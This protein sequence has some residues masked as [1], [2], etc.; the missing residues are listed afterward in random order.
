MDNVPPA[1]RIVDLRIGTQ[2]A[3]DGGPPERLR[4]R[5]ALQQEGR[6]TRI[7]A[8]VL[9]PHDLRDS[10][11]LFRHNGDTAEAWYYNPVLDRVRR[12]TGSGNTQAL[13]GTA[14]SPDDF[15][16]VERALRTASITLRP[17]RDDDPPDQRRFIVLPP[18]G[19]DLPLSRILLNVHTEYCVI[20]RAE[21]LDRS[22][23]P[24][25]RLIVPPGALQR[26]GGDRYW[27]P[28]RM[29]FENLELQRTSEVQVEGIELPAALPPALFDPERFYRASQ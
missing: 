1:L 28:R 27:Y 24:V 2:N 8:R 11:W 7:S 12:V 13:F 16:T 6:A 9:A 22:R 15:A 4:L 25:R 29:R 10:A 5:V 18:P 21:L 14:I 17:R 26:I 19:S 23:S 3:G 20:V